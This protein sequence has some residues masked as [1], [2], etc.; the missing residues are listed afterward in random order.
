MHLPDAQLPYLTSQLPAHSF[1]ESSPKA[2]GFIVLVRPRSHQPDLFYT[3][4]YLAL[5]ERELFN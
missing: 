5:I 3:N 4:R 1:L 2:P